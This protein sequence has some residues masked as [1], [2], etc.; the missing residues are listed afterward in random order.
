MNWD[1]LFHMQKELDTYIE[2]HNNLTGE[3]LFKRKVLA[4]MVELGELANE[5]RCFKFWSAKPASARA[6]ILEEYVDGLHFI[7]SL[8]I[9]IEAGMGTEDYEEY[10]DLTNGFLKVY[11]EVNRFSTSPC[12][13][14]YQAL[15]TSYL[16]L[17]RTIGFS[18]Q[19]V[20][21]AYLAKNKVNYERQD[22]GY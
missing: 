6:V 8:G 5:T 16:T 22:K 2:N 15:F 19:D 17:G 18:E 9:E 14:T 20:Q 12:Q 21:D 7:L 4:L 10:A 1:E 11:E 13:E 3:A